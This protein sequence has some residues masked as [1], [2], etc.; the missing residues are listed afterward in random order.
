MKLVWK[1]F[2]HLARTSKK[3]Q[4]VFIK[5]YLSVNAVKKAK[6]VYSETHTKHKHIL[7]HIWAY[8][9]VYKFSFV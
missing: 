9:Y 8:I 1:L 5:N 7:K 2:K 6:G 4:R 3:T